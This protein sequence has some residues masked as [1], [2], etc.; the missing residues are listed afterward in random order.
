[1][2]NL[3]GIHKSLAIAPGSGTGDFVAIAPVPGCIIVPTM[4]YLTSSAA[5]TLLL[6]N[7]GSGNL[8]GDLYIAALGAHN[9][10]LFNPEGICRTKSGEGLNITRST[11][12]IVT[13]IVTYKLLKA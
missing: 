2:E 4:I 5:G 1:M 9:I 11:T 10:N 12:M 6:K 7:S 8:S 13:G 3:R